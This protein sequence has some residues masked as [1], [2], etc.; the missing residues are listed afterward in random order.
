MRLSL[1]LMVSPAMAI[2]LTA[3]IAIILFAPN[4]TVTNAQQQ[5]QLTS[6]P[7]AT[8]N[9][10][11]FQNIEDGFRVQVPQ[12]WV[13]HDM[14]NTGFALLEEVMQGY[15]I[16]AQ[17]CPEEQQQA[18][19]NVGSGTLS[20]CEG[21][22]EDVIYIV[23]YPNLGARL[24]FASDDITTISN[25]TINHI[26]SY[27]IQK[28]QEVGY[29]DIQ[30]LNS[31]DTIVAV[32]TSTEAGI[33]NNAVPTA[34]VP[35]KFVQMTY[36]TNFAPNEIRTGYFVLTAT[37]ATPRNEITGYSIFYEG[38]PQATEATTAS[39]S[40]PSS[41]TAAVRQVFGSFELIAAEE[42]TQ[43]VAETQAEQTEQTNQ[44]NSERTNDG[45]GDDGGGN[46]NSNGGSSNDD[47][48]VVGR[49]ADETDDHYDGDDCDACDD[50]SGEEASNDDATSVGGRSVDDAY[51]AD[52]DGE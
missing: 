8:L 14:E 31:T 9:G 3:A 35:A 50:N 51:G 6:Q 47:A 10:T 39:G 12:G 41:T 19:R 21:S 36:S 43:A 7:A 33:N 32:G 52:N 16:L 48:R 27:Q 1:P 45:D 24:G 29:R 25:N 15:A 4:F 13:V 2:G 40:L 18:L 42:V 17:L 26:L 20:S 37:N 38:P 23:R 22:E 30:I 44:P 28:L 11:T 46:D 49:P 5:Q 34:T